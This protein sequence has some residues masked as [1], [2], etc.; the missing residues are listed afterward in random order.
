[1]PQSIHRLAFGLINH[2]IKGRFRAEARNFLSIIPS[3]L[4]LGQIASSLS[5]GP[6][7]KRS[8]LKITAH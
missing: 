2:G 4:E 7:V 8:G 3:R 6:D 5:C 1:M